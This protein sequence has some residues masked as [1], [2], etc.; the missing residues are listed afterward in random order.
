M[1]FP[2]LDCLGAFQ[3]DIRA[4]KVE[5][6]MPF[7]VELRPRAMKRIRE[8]TFDLKRDL[9]MDLDLEGEVEERGT[10]DSKREVERKA[11]SRFR[12]GVMQESLFG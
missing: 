4:R 7:G 5:D 8:G 12:D 9:P 11:K 2:E 6:K 1:Y 3:N 10:G